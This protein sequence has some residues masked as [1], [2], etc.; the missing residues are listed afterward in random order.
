MCEAC[1]KV[2]VEGVCEA[3][4][5]EGYEGCGMCVKGCVRGVCVWACEA[6]GWLSAHG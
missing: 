4:V 2:Y 6:R 1:I 3:Y 5:C